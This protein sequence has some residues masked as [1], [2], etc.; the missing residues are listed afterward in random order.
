VTSLNIDL[1]TTSI[2]EQDKRLEA[3]Y[4]KTKEDPKNFTA[5]RQYA[6]IL[7][8]RPNKEK[9]LRALQSLEI[10]LSE[11]KEDIESLVLRIIALRYTGEIKNAKILAEDYI[12][13]YPDT[14]G[15][16]VQLISILIIQNKN[17][18]A[19]GHLKTA[20]KKFY[21]DEKIT[22]LNIQ[23][24][25]SLRKWDRVLTLCNTSL[26][27]NPTDQRTVIYKCQSL[28]FLHKENEAILYFEKFKKEFP[29]QFNLPMWT[30]GGE[31]QSC[32]YNYALHCKHQAK[33]ESNEH[34]N[35]IV[36][37][38]QLFF[39]S[40]L[41]ENSKNLLKKAID[42]TTEILSNTQHHTTQNNIKLLQAECHI[43]LEKFQESML[44]LN[45]ISPEYDFENT[46]YAKIK[47][48]LLSKEFQK[49]TDLCLTYLDSFPDN[50]NTKKIISYSY[51]GLGNTSEYEKRM[52][53]IK[54]DQKNDEPS[55]QV[56]TSF[57]INKNE[58]Y[59]NYKKFMDLMNNFSGEVFIINSYTKA[60]IVEFIRIM[61]DDPDNKVT[62]VSIIG[63]IFNRSDGGHQFYNQYLKLQEEVRIFNSQ[64]VGCQIKFRIN[65]DG[66]HARYYMDR[67]QVYRGTGDEQVLSSSI[68]DFQ[69][70]NKQKDE[71][72][73]RKTWTRLWIDPK[74]F[75]LPSNSE[76][77]E[78]WKKILTLYD[79]KRDKF[80]HEK[81]DI[82]LIPKIEQILHT[83][84]NKKS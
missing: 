74:C 66:A 49:C 12:E 39:T 41:S 34:Q 84:K 28:Y 2:V 18:Q 78:A 35:V 55:E 79:D 45:D 54:N 59:D 50:K 48:L 26:Q 37:N 65:N 16:H 24:Y 29:R 33:L 15:F 71:D 8:E 60:K 20:L 22:R 53:E 9:A 57:H 36:E 77:V 23:V 80:D 14:V 52:S 6:E 56:D 67:N 63:G 4:N 17:D 1:V 73:I 25:S 31:Y 83:D 82:E 43:E 27:S 68:D 69:L 58:H 32:S 42:E 81:K 10:I 64:K 44:V 30:M 70:V 72:D 5:H 38:N 13:K 3:L 46:G 51:L 47:T 62:K 75:P 11:K 40:K 7:L 61:V 76:D 19:K 21:D